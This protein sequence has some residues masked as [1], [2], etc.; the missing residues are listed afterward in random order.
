MNKSFQCANEISSKF[1]CEA[2]TNLLSFLIDRASKNSKLANYLYWYLLIEFE[3]CEPTNKQE[4]ST[5]RMYAAV[6]KIFV[7]TLA[8][9]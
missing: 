2:Q 1:L 5:R 6:S 7:N 4:E 3:S 9:G 8:S